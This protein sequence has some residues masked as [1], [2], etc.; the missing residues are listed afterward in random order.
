MKRCTILFSLSTIDKQ[1]RTKFSFLISGEQ[2]TERG[3][4]VCR[5]W[6]PMMKMHD[7]FSFLDYH[8][9]TNNRWLFVK[10]ATRGEAKMAALP[11]KNRA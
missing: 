2:R 9:P 7:W 10:A 3:G 8:L 4:S 5:R 1:Q 6:R 11:E